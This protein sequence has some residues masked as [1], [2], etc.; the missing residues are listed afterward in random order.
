MT[1]VTH[2]DAKE[3]LVVEFTTVGTDAVLPGGSLAGRFLV[4]QLLVVAVVLIAVAAVS[5]AQSTR[6]F[7]DVR[8][9][10]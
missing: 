1:Q 2:S 5:V 9:S 8:G 6:E 7:R 10:G 4:F 3:V